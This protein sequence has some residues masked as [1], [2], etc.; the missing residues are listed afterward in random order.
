VKKNIMNHTINNISLSASMRLP[1]DPGRFFGFKQALN[2]LGIYLDKMKINQ[3]IK[4]N[5][6]HA[7]VCYTIIQLIR[8]G[9]QSNRSNNKVILNL[10]R[11]CIS[12]KMLQNSLHHYAPLSEDSK[13]IPFLIKI[14]QPLLLFYACKIRGSLR[15]K[16]NNSQLKT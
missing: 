4:H 14:R 3:N 8:L 10:I 15:Y 7:Y 9:F 6:S 5:I 13:I 16:V 1:K 11:D 2:S 12:D